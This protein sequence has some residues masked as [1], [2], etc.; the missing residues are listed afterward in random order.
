MDSGGPC[1]ATNEKPFCVPLRRCSRENSPLRHGRAAVRECCDEHCPDSGVSRMTKG[2]LLE[3]IL[4]IALSMKFAAMGSGSH[5][6]EECVGAWLGP[7]YAGS[8]PK[9]LMVRA[10][11][12]TWTQDPDN[13]KR[14]S[15]AKG[16]QREREAQGRD[17]E[18]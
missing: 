9:D 4:C 11:S 10:R 1:P 8:I 3:T 18:R 16:A 14:P 6:F 7:V 15:K 5:K 17:R 2:K 12:D 13:G